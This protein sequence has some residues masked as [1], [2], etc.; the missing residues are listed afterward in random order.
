MKKIISLLL[1]MAVLLSVM[2]LTAFAKGDTRD[3]D[4]WIVDCVDIEVDQPVIGG[5]ISD[6]YTLHPTSEGFYVADVS[7][8]PE[9]T[10]FRAG[11]AY[12]VTITVEA[13]EG[14][15]FNLTDDK[16]FWINAGVAT[17]L[18]RS[19]DQI[20]ACYTFAPLMPNFIDV[21]YDYSAVSLQLHENFTLE[22]KYSLPEGAKNVKHQ[23]FVAD[24]PS[25][26]GT[27]IEGATSKTLGVPNDEEGIKYYRCHITCEVNGET[28]STPTEEFYT[29]KVEVKGFGMPSMFFEDVKSYD[30][31]YKDVEFVYYDRLMVGIDETHFGPDVPTTRGMIV[32][33]LYRLEGQPDVGTN[34]PFSDVKKGSYYEKAIIWAEKNG[35]V[36]GMGDGTYEPD[37]QIT[38]EQLAA[39]L[40]R[41]AK[42]KG[43]WNEDDCVM[44]GGFSDLNKVS[45]WASEDIS[46]AVGSGMLAGS[47]EADGLYI[48]PQGNALRSHFAAMLHRFYKY[49]LEP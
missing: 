29:V 42:F 9:D 38:R 43:V 22:A 35:I 5:Y 45:S 10:S 46:W 47:Q 33:V 18:S 7:W 3:A 44:T 23:W 4:R 32:T 40:C 31:F 16:I 36:Y 6:L 30:W 8:S 1:I 28:L 24:T 41:Y 11:V 34:C 14:F 49:F 19:A 26:W 15:T 39:I 17:I 13:E 27:A 12:T 2:S 48:M 37:T 20:K 25:A 21:S